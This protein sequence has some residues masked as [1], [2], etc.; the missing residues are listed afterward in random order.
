MTSPTFKIAHL[1]ALMSR[2]CP[3]ISAY[4]CADIAQRLTSISSAIVA[5]YEFECN[6][7]KNGWQ[8]QH[9]NKLS[10]TD[11]K[12]AI[13]YCNK[14]NSEGAAYCEK[15][16]T[17]LNKKLEKLATEHGLNLASADLS[18]VLWAY[19]DNREYYI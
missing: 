5:V 14:L 10:R 12:A 15:R 2:Q 3:K 9:L 16:K 7:Y 8:D 1:A 18:G 11:K 6:G 19:A 13:E 4:T 17:A